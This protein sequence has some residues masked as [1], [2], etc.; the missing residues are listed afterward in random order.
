M[1]AAHIRFRNGVTEY[2]TKTGRTNP[3][4]LGTLS[5]PHGHPDTGTIGKTPGG[6]GGSIIL[7]TTGR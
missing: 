5:T 7:N 1:A 4:V 3:E 6:N 2:I